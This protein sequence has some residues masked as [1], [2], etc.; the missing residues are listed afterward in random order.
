MLDAKS[1]RKES[2][3][4][5]AG[6]VKGHG[7]ALH[8]HLRWPSLHIECFWEDPFAIFKQVSPL[9]LVYFRVYE[10]H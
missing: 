3:K 5:G 8:Q 6:L 4:I 7:L 9:L 1:Q 2:T 10:S